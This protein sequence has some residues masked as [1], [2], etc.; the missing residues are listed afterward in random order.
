MV[1]DSFA[2]YSGDD[3]T[4]AQY[5]LAGAVGNISVTANVVPAKVAALC[6]AA[7]A[8]DEETVRRMDD[9]LAGINSTL[10]IEANPMPVKYALAKMGRM[11]EG[12]RLPLTL[13]EGENAERIAAALKSLGL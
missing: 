1:P 9:E 8:G 10:F 3:G 13:P 6:A 2:V 11:E 7:L 4:A 5:I 12:I